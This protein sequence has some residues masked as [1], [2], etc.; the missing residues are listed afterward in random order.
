MYRLR[1]FHEPEIDKERVSVRLLNTERM[2]EVIAR[3]DENM[4]QKASRNA[5]ALF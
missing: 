5:A 4:K 3:F 1:R 2:G